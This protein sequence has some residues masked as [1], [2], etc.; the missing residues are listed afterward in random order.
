MV[1]LANNKLS[2]TAWQL[3]I[4]INKAEDSI[5]TLD[6]KSRKIASIT[7]LITS[8]EFDQLKSLLENCKNTTAISYKDIEETIIHL[9]NYAGFPKAYTALRICREVFRK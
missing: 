4:G 3:F 7:A 1:A 5:S 8:G 6:L 2:N 9:I